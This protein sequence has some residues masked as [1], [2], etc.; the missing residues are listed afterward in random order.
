MTFATRFAGTF[1]LA[2]LAA[3]PIVAEQAQYQPQISVIGEGV[4]TIAPDLAHITV[5]VTH[6]AKTAAEAMD[7]MNADLQSVLERLRAAGIEA[8]HM[9]TSQLRLNQIYEH[10]DNR[11]EA[12]GYEASSDLNIQVHDLP[13]L[14]EVLDAVVRDGANEMRGLRFDVA[15]RDPHLEAARK[16]AV[17][18][19]LSKA[20]LYAGAAGVDL[21]AIMLI[22]EGGGQASPRPMMEASF[23]GARSGSVPIAAGEL[24]VRATVSMV[25]AIGD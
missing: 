4:V 17:A 12:A 16:A 2:I 1:G 25:W 9:Q 8:R 15:D 3:T 13:K 18:D 7:A 11:R 6:Q 23:D 10:Y 5:G 14:G 20:T 19:A 24:E 22:S 21:G